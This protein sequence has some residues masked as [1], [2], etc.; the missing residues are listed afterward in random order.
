MPG[1]AGAG[2]RGDARAAAI[3]ATLALVQSTPHTGRDSGSDDNSVDDA[4]VQ[5]ATGSPVQG[6]RLPPPSAH[7]VGSEAAQGQPQG[8]TRA[9]PTTFTIPTNPA[10]EPHRAYNPAPANHHEHNT[11]PAYH[12]A[13][14]GQ[15]PNPL[16]HGNSRLGQHPTYGELHGGLHQSVSHTTGFPPPCLRQNHPPPKGTRREETRSMEHT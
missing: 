1:R 8:T 6:R 3:S 11:G 4:S 10:P 15:Q 5:A 14:N 7:Q 9:A 12:P 13:P 2:K 16:P